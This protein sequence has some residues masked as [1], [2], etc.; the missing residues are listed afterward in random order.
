MAKSKIIILGAGLAGL[1][2]AW[3]LQRKGRDC[4]VFEKEAEVG[5]L[6]RSKRIGGFTFDYDGHLL[7]FKYDYTFKLVGK[8][9]GDNLRRHKRRASVYSNGRYIHYPF[10]ANLHGLPPLI[11]KECLLGFISASGGAGVGQ[12]NKR[13]LNFLNWINDTFGTGIAK[14]FMIPYNTK[15][16]T[17]P[18]AS[19]TCDWLEGFIPVPSLSQVVEGA[20]EESRREFGYN[21]VFW[22]PGRGGISHLPLA[23]ASSVRNIYTNYRVTGINLEKK[24]ITTESGN[25]ERFDSLISTIPLPEM[26]HIVSGLPDKISLL[27]KRLKWNS[28][29]NINLGLSTGGYPGN[30]WVYFPQKDISFFR[31]GFPHN[32]SSSIAPHGKSSLYAEVSYSKDKPIDKKTIP[33]C[34]MSDLK[35]VGIIKKGDE[36]IASDMN[37]IKYGYPIYDAHYRDALSKITGYFA[38]KGMILCG[39]YGSW[40]YMSMEGVILD[41]RNMAALF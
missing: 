1:S 24:Y 38:S 12:K 36:V 41:G 39:R 34:V 28:I 14:H 23:L 31:V 29:F 16:W 21:A 10:Q 26:A 19:M 33:S 18:P 22:Y 20:I 32:F 35:K 8:L 15:F 25:K 2:A 6:C 13:G 4:Q 27:L 5:G 37:D 30:H 11:A 7:H 9:L 40:R 17:I 3:H